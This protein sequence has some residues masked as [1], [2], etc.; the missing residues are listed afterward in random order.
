[1]V[2]QRTETQNGNINGAFFLTS[3]T[4]ARASHTL[5]SGTV[6]S[7]FTDTGTEAQR[8]GWRSSKH[9]C[10]DSN[11]S[12]PAPEPTVTTPPGRGGRI[13]SHSQRK[14]SSYRSAWAWGLAHNLLE[15]FTW[16][17]HL[18]LVKS[19]IMHRILWKTYRNEY[20]NEW[21]VNILLLKYIKNHI[22]T[23]IFLENLSM[24]HFLV[25]DTFSSF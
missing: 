10:G 1:M 6:S 22:W 11:P 13:P 23:F 15:V 17:F 4:V 5:G 7:H 12:R 18:E 14:M 19:H 25:S 16:H 2:A 20:Y 9:G 3:P 21:I 8:P 24:E